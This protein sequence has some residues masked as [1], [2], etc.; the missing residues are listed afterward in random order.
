MT[1]FTNISNSVSGIGRTWLAV[2]LLT[3]L[4]VS[5]PSSA[6]DFARLGERQILGTARYVSMGGAMSAIGGDPSSTYDNIA[7]LGMYR[8]SEVLLTLNESLDKT[9]ED[10]NNYVA[11]RNS[12]YAAQAS[13]V[14]SMPTYREDK[15][16][17][18]HN[19][20]FSY[21]RQKS[22]ERDI[23]ASTLRNMPSMGELL[24]QQDID[25]TLPYCQAPTSVSSGLQ[26]YEYGYVNE[27]NIGWAMNHSN[28][29]YF[30]AGVQIQSG[31]LTSDAS[32]TETFYIIN[33]EGRYHTNINDSRLILNQVGASASLGLIARPL[34]WLRLGLGLQTA[35]V[36]SFKTYTA[37]EFS[38]MTDSLRHSWAPEQQ[39]TTDAYHAPWHIS[40]SVAF[41][42]GAY[43]LIALQY[44][45]RKQKDEY[46][47]HSLRAGFEVIPVLGFYINGGYAYESSFKDDR[48]IVGMDPSFNRQDMYFQHPVGAHYASIALG[49]RG[50]HVIVQAAYQYRAE[51]LHLWAHEN[52]DPYLVHADTHR[53]VLTLGWHRYY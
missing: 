22:F 48:R 36:G 25:W 17:L 28:R 7:G 46:S 50:T 35:S 47:M 24:S 40:S 27:F 13:I 3:A 19:V 20:I 6:Q 18:F 8:R 31:T 23:Y 32:Y 49:Y 12:V 9:Q 45:W 53:V 5:L 38:A 2:S 15:G 41:Q 16:V 29:W 34:G 44:D 43:G 33:E 37:G 39:F 30:G 10:G 52:A 14:I 21:Q 26:L 51:T 11:Y 4:A 42:I 1:R